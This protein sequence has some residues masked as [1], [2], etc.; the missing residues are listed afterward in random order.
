MRFFRQ[1]IFARRG[2][3]RPAGLKS[4]ANGVNTWGG[5]TSGAEFKK[6]L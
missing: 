6:C 1:I 5:K 3:G 4:H 2:D